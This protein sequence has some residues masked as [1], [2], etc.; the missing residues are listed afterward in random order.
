MN[1][2]KEV[3]FRSMEYP[4]ESVGEIKAQIEAGLAENQE[5]ETENQKLQ[6]KVSEF[7]AK[8]SKP[9]TRSS[10]RKRHWR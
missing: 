10:E 2:L 6:A 7:E 8:S 4:K 5:L 1:L 9:R 3:E